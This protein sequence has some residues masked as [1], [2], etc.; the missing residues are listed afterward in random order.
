MPFIAL[1]KGFAPLEI[2]DR[3]LDLYNHPFAATSSAPGF[4]RL[5]FITRLS[6]G[7]FISSVSSFPLFDGNMSANL[8]I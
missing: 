2:L 7:K 3:H 4:H 6:V 5:T 1:Q 8:H